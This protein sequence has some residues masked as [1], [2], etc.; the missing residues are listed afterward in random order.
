MNATKLSDLTA[1]QS[2]WLK[3]EDLKNKAITVRIFG[4]KLEDIRQQN[5]EKETKIVLS[6]VGAK[7]RLILN[8]SQAIALANISKTEAFAAWRGLSIML[9][10][11]L[12]QNKKPT[13]GIFPAHLRPAKQATGPPS[14]SFRPL[15]AKRLYRPKR[16]SKKKT[17]SRGEFT[18]CAKFGTSGA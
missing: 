6:F 15:Q 13:I 11:G 1:Y 4:V 2:P 12:A 16:K 9:Q 3:P 14:K 18:T 5:G 10:P 17:P 8:K 7:K